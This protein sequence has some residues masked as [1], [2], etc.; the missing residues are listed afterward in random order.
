[1][2]KMYILFTTLLI[3]L[4]SGCSTQSGTSE[5]P[6]L[7]KSEEI[8]LLPVG[9]TT[10]PTFENI[11]SG[12]NNLL[13]STRDSYNIMT[14]LAT[15]DSAPKKGI[16]AAQKVE[17]KYSARLAELE[18]ADLSSYSMEELEEI[19]I[20]LSNMITAIREARDLLSE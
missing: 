16:K 10:E 2:K 14:E 19:S 17:K 13:V 9:P 7:I 3:L 20:E 1:M 4:L 8:D 11:L 12:T 6:A 15:R 18:N 5:D